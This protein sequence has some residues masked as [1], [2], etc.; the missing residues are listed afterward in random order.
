MTVTKTVQEHADLQAHL[1]LCS[2]GSI[3]PFVVWFK[4]FYSNLFMVP[5]PSEGIHPILDLKSLNKLFLHSKILKEISKVSSCLSD[6]RTH[7][8]CKS[9][10]CLSTCSHLPTSA[11]ST[12]REHFQFVTLPFGLSC[13]PGVLTKILPF[14]A[15]LRASR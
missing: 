12:A 4:G 2:R 6:T 13:V 5:K 11:V 1:F 14:L 9:T 3:Q 10:K 7:G 8:I 15:L